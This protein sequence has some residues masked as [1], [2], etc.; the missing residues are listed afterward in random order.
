MKPGGELGTAVSVLNGSC[1]SPGRISVGSSE[2][3]MLNIGSPCIGDELFS[4]G[5]SGKS[6]EMCFAGV[7]FFEAFLSSGVFRMPRLVCAV[8]GLRHH[9]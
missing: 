7:L 6:N 4:D 5:R 2:K 3:L 9:A 1:M 8:Q